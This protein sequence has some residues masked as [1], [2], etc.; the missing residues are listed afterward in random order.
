TPSIMQGGDWRA[1]ELAVNRLLLHCGWKDIQYVGESGDKGADLLAVRKGQMDGRAESYLIQV[2][3]IKSSS[4]IGKSAIDQ[5][6]QGQSFYRAKIVIVA[7]NGDFTKSA[8]TRRDELRRE[9]YDVRLW[10]GKFLQE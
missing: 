10:N 2:K 1:L 5:A 7:T 6:I 9:G 4:Y 3:A 8:F